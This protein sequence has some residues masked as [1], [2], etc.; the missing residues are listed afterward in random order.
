MIELT[1]KE[2]EMLSTGIIFSTSKPNPLFIKDGMEGGNYVCE[3]YQVNDQLTLVIYDLSLSTTS[4]RIHID[5][6]EIE[7]IKIH[8][9]I[10][11]KGNRRYQYYKIKLRTYEGE[12]L[13][14]EEGEWSKDFTI[15]SDKYAGLS[16]DTQAKRYFIDFLRIYLEEKGENEKN[17]MEEPNTETSE[18][19]EVSPI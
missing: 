19:N 6:K 13:M 17:S 9:W 1:E 4:Q 8:S 7:H 16:L 11:S 2:K 3:A 12:L 14:C 10:D 18:E 5:G 15:W